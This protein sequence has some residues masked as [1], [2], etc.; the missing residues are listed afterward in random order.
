MLGFKFV[1]LPALILLALGAVAQDTY[2]EPVPLYGQ[3]GTIVGTVC[4]VPHLDAFSL[5]T[6][7][8]VASLFLWPIETL[9]P[10]QMLLHPPGR[11]DVSPRILCRRDK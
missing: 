6:N 9:C 1:S 3:C 2:V 10:R 4:I 7:D 5:F 11:W 8:R